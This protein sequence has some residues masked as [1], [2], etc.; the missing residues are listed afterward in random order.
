MGIA[1]IPNPENKPT[2]NHIDGIKNHNM[3]SNLE[4]ATHSE[5]NYHAYRTGLLV[6]KHNTG[7]FGKFLGDHWGA[8][9][10]VQSTKT[11]EFVKEY[12]CAREAV[13]SGFNY[14]SISRCC[15]GDKKSHGGFIW[16]F[17]PILNE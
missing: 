4:W 12:T 13:L 1:F 14:K 8:K 9:P 16:K 2:I 17:K 11:G 5:Q 7:S 3:I 6:H 10:V 15:N